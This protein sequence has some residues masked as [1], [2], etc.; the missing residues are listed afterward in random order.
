MAVQ[1]PYCSVQWWID[2][3][4]MQRYYC[5]D[6]RGAGVIRYQETMGF[7]QG[8]RQYDLSRPCINCTGTGMMGRFYIPAYGHSCPK[9]GL[10]P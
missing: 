3:D 4:G 8:A 9:C 7:E 2:A 1:C 5:A 6:C 10:R